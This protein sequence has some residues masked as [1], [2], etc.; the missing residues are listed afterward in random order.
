MKRYRK[1][2]F[3][4]GD[5]RRFLEPGPVVLVGTAH[6]G[7]RDVMTMGWH[8]VL[9]FAPSLLACCLSRGNHSHRLARA[10]GECTIHLPTADIVDTVVGIGN[11]SGADTDKFARFG[12]TTTPASEVGAP[13][14][15]QCYASFECR[16]HDDS[17][18]ERYDLFVWEVVKAHVAPVPKLPCT[19][20][21]R[22]DGQFM[23][24]GAEISRRRLFRPEML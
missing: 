22:G 4:V 3:P 9:E 15:D 23:L 5:V 8:M 12:L 18:V 24:A 21:Y 20:H 7:E 16:L 17:L 2:D 10:S 19:V 11:C 1:Q 6:A 13:L 14:I